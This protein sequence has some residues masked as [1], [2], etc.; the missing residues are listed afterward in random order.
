MPQSRLASVFY[1]SILFLLLS[2]TDLPPALCAS[3]NVTCD[4]QFGCELS[5]DAQGATI[6]YIP[7]DGWTQGSTCTGCK[8]VADPTQAFNGTWH[9]TTLGKEEAGSRLFNITF[10]GKQTYTEHCFIQGS[11]AL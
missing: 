11:S 5:G 4:D 9:D 2:L 3:K 10:Q 7:N 6:E 8:I 1:L